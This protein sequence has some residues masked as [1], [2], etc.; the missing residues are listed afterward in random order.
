MELTEVRALQNVTIAPH[1]Q[2]VVMQEGLKYEI[3]ADTVDDYV[4]GRYVEVVEQAKPT[5][6]R[7]TSAK[8]AANA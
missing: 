4:R 6:K 8:G 3:P 5:P 7:K 2:Q 1:G